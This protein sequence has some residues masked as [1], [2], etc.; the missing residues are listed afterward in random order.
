[1]EPSEN[2][3]RDNQVHLALQI[4]AMLHHNDHR[5][6]HAWIQKI[7]QEIFSIDVVDVA[8]IA[9]SPALRPRI[10]ELKSVAAVLK[11]RLT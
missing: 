10:N 5:D 7:K 1:M 6:A 3:I 8:V 2:G 4:N 9:V 11:L